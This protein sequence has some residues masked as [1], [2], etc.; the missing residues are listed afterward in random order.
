MPGDELK[1]ISNDLIDN[2]L[3]GLIDENNGSTFGEGDSAIVRYLYD[4]LKYVDYLSGENGE[5]N[6][7]IDEKRDDGLDNDGDW[8]AKFDD[9]GL[10]GVPNTGDFGEGDGVPTS[11]AGTDLPGEPHIDK[12]D[13]DESDMIG[14]TA[15]NIYSPW[16]IYPL[17]NDEV[18]WEAIYPG[19]LNAMGQIGNT[20]IMLGSG[21]FPLVPG[22]IERF[23]VG[24]IMGYHE[25]LFRNKEYFLMMY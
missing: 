15:F 7:L 17:Y 14:L 9:V 20:D 5:N 1:E 25:E 11:G 3:N 23:S 18:L 24:Y 19:F 13:I 10:D 12:T 2:N 8:V 21:F 4:G 22:Q 6:L 16:T